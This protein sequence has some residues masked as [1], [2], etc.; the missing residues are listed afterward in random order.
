CVGAEHEDTGMQRVNRLSLFECEPLHVGRRILRGVAGLID[1]RRD[2]V[3]D[4][5]DL[6]EKLATARRGG[7]EDEPHQGSASTEIEVSSTCA[8]RGLRVIAFSA[9]LADSMQSM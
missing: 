1:M 5:A 7:G 9:A 8:S 4:E 2:D 6:R 3:E